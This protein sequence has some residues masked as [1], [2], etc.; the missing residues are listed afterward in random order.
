MVLAINTKTGIIRDLP[1]NVV[2]HRVLGKHLEVYVE[3]EE[4]L[5]KVVIEKRVYK[6]KSEKSEAPAEDN[7]TQ[8]EEPIVA[9]D[10]S[11]VTE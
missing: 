7:I 5:D 2:N 6:K 1:L 4:E 10:F 8:I 9:T 3:D 11:E